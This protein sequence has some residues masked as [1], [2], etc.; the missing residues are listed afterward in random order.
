MRKV[1]VWVDG[2]KKYQELAKHDYSHYGLMDGTVTLSPGTHQVTIIA[3]GYDNLEVKK[4]Y[5]ITV[6]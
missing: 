1:E 5:T 4:S 3:A 2:V 6:Q